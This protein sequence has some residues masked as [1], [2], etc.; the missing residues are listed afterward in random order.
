MVYKWYKHAFLIGN[1]EVDTDSEE[2][3]VP[4]ADILIHFC[5]LV[6]F[7]SLHCSFSKHVFHSKDEKHYACWSEVVNKA[8]GH[9]SEI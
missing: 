9:K 8:I 3:L 2:T 4:T 1:V 6:G 5:S 7:V